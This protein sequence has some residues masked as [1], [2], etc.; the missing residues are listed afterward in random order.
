M[1]RLG[2]LLTAMV[3]PFDEGMKVDF[4]R[5][6][7]L[8]G[9]LLKS[10]TDGIVLSGTTGE[11]PTLSHEE[12][13]R[14]FTEIKDVV[15]DKGSVVAGTGNNNTAESVKFS[16][17][18]ETTGVDAILLVVPYYNKP[19]QE[20]LYL[21]FKAIAEATKLPCILYD[22]PSRTGISLTPETVARLSK[23]PNIV[24]IKD[25]SAD[26]GHV[27][28]IIDA[29]GSDFIMYSGNDADTVPIMA[30]GG[31]GVV[32]VASHLVGKQV[33]AMIDECVEGHYSEAAL[34]HRKLLPLVNAMF[35]TTNPTPVKY[36]LNKVGFNVGKPRLPL[37]EPDDDCKK[38]IDAVLK[39]YKIDLP[40]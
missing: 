1:V 34:M 35:L 40:I 33:H 17:E 31:Y 19:Q 2:R 14:L 12:K 37:V 5:A 22:V 10:G 27:A 9:A 24:G 7:K 26:L 4:A 21:H 20:G 39:N 6:R 32:S 25:A 36:A 29:T 28:R 11:S 18:A 23:I 8:A 3:T 38:K 30:L 13:L 15:G 16:Q